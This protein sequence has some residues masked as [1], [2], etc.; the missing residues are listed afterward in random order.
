MKL[1]NFIICD[2]IR[3]ELGNKNSLMGI[4]DDTIDFRVTPD[5]EKNWPKVMR[6]GIY[7]RILIDED[8]NITH[9]KLKSLFN[10]KETIIGDGIL[11]LSKL[12]QLKKINI[13][14]IHNSFVFEN[15][16]NI[17]FIF[18]FYNDKDEIVETLQPDFSLEV[19]ETITN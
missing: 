11:N 12:K 14:I 13:A 15:T 7:A 9:F 8:K 2:D 5:K 4:Y 16:G 1:I 17:K 3:S 10:K 6:I 18:D 19:K